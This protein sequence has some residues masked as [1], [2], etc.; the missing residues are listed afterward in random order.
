V[1][2]LIMPRVD[3]GRVCRYLRE[4]FRLRHIT[5]LVFSA[6]A[7][8][9]IVAM[10][11]VAAAAYVTKGPLPIVTKTSWP[12]SNTWSATADPPPSRRLFSATKVSA[13]GDW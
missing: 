9:D 13:R 8:K 6:P 5:I 12:L 10:Q 11:D 1:L 4:D 7:A 3:G 2:D